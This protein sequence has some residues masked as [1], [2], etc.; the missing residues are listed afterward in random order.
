MSNHPISFTIEL[1]TDEFLTSGIYSATRDPTHLGGTIP[2]L[3]FCI[4]FTFFSHFFTFTFFYSTIFI[5]LSTT[6]RP[7][8]YICRILM[9]LDYLINV[10]HFKIL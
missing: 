3:L 6:F 9:S 7:T 4:F 8:S 2:P 5:L 10:Q 1:A